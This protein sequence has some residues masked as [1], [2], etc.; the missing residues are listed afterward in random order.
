[1]MQHATYQDA[2]C[3]AG[4]APV[5]Q[6]AVVAAAVPVAAPGP[7]GSN[8]SVRGCGC[9]GAQNSESV[10]ANT[11]LRAHHAKLDAI[12]AQ[13]YAPL[14][15]AAQSGHVA[16]VSAL[17][18]ARRRRNHATVLYAADSAAPRCAV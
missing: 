16:N 11:A 3:S 10:P 2:T 1:M 9:P 15:V 4:A 17:L 6:V 18:E 7:T 14:H 5:Q 8:S 13:G 12:C